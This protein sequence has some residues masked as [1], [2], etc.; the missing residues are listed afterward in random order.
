[1]RVFKRLGIFLALILFL[2]I[3]LTGFQIYLD[4]TKREEDMHSF[5][6]LAVKDAIVNIQTTEEQGLNFLD[7][8]TERKTTEKYKEYLNALASSTNNAEILSMLQ[9]FLQEN[10]GAKGNDRFQPIQFGMTYIDTELFKES[11]IAS[12]Q[13]L[14]DSNY[15]LDSAERAAAAAQGKTNA[16]LF[17][18][19]ASNTLAFK[20]D[21]SQTGSFVPDASLAD[22][23]TGK[24]AISF[25]GENY[26]VCIEIKKP[27]VVELRQY[28]NA[29]YQQF[30]RS[31]YGNDNIDDYI[32]AYSNSGQDLGI[33]VESMPNFFIYYDIN[34]TVC[35]ASM[36]TNPLLR[37]GFL[38]DIWR[39]PNSYFSRD[40]GYLMIPG[41]P[42][43]YNYRYVL[44]N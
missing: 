42:I 21:I 15:S 43:E 20:S 6:R 37:K 8:V 7:S 40:N 39:V 2:S 27:E 11:F 18:T 16:K 22:R 12:L 36:T 17:G 5:V 41:R 34:V 24:Q 1:M 33:S 4:V 3:V 26:E 35:W 25:R 13:K 30:I 32:N 28:S 19:Q 10:S 9:N 14:I 31:L 23:Y 29:E 44:L 38:G